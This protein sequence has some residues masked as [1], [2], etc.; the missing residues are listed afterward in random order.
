[1]TQEEIRLEEARQRQAHWKRW[2][3]C[4]SERRSGDR[5]PCNKSAQA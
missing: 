3:P 2:G 4:L 1:M 5:A